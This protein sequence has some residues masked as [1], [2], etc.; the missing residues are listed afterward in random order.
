MQPR[1]VCAWPGGYPT[2]LTS[3]PGQELRDCLASEKKGVAFNREKGV[4]GG[5]CLPFVLGGSH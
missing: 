2:A 3:F 4:G 1:P 5:R